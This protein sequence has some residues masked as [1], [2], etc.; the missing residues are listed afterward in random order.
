M[1]KKFSIVIPSRGAG[2]GLWATIQSCQMELQKYDYDYE[3]VV[4][5]N[6]EKLPVE[7]QEIVRGVKYSGHLGQH[8]HSD[9][10]LAPP[11][12]RQ[13]GV[14]VSQG[15]LIFFFDNHC[16]VTPRYFERAIVHMEAFNI[17]L[18]HSATRFQHGDRNHHHYK[19]TLDYN[20]WGQ[21]GGPPL[22]EH[23]PYKVAMGGHGGIVVRKSVWDEV[24]GYGPEGVLV[25]YGGEEPM[26]DLKLW[27]MGKNVWLDARLL[28]Y[29][30]AGNR[31]YTAHFSDDYYT[32]M[33]V[34]AH[35]IGGEKWLYKVFDSFISKYHIR[36]LTDDKLTPMQILE[37]AYNRSAEYA[38]VVDKMSVRTLDDCLGEYF[39][40]NEIAY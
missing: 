10:A 12:A 7:V 40:M 34:A 29:H 5:T 36:P 15:E 25:G 2:L 21:A 4:V 35:V 39:R 14:E 20:F 23:K 37:N 3:I 1:S 8:I 32:N 16:L 11:V 17:D 28:H 27:R 6:G 26:F 30:Y 24:G 13:R 9:V 31:G 33:L 38:S 22:W 19:L 18:L